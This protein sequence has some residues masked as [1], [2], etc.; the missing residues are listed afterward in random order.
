V[1]IF[2]FAVYLAIGALISYVARRI[3]ARMNRGSR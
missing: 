1:Y 2:L 3:E